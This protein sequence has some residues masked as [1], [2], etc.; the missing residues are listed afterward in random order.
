MKK[1]EEF[2]K[3]KKQNDIAAVA[4]CIIKNSKQVL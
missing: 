1:M 3:K 2:I 4:K